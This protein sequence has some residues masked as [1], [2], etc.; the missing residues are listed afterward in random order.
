MS[1]VMRREAVN[2][3][4][5]VEL[6]PET[7]GLISKRLRPNSLLVAREIG[8]L[9]SASVNRLAAVPNPDCA[10]TDVPD[11]VDVSVPVRIRET[12]S[13]CGK[14]GSELTLVVGCDNGPSILAVTR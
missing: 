12:T 6:V 13:A 11:S 9:I 10:S 14:E 1:F 5:G 7:T 4:V 8:A 3:A 2:R